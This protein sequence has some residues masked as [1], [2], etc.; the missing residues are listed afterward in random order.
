MWLRNSTTTPSPT[1]YAVLTFPQA[2]DILDVDGDSHADVAV[3]GGG[4]PDSIAVFTNN[5]SGGL[6]TPSLL[7]TPAGQFV[8]MALRDLNADG[9]PDILL[10]GILENSVDVMFGVGDGTF[11]PERG[12]GTG[13][14]PTRL[15]TGDFH[16]TGR[17]DVA[18]SCGRDSVISLLAN[19]GHILAVPD[20]ASRS[21]TTLAMRVW[22]VPS[23]GTAPQISC[24]LPR[25]ETITVRAVDVAGRQIGTL[26]RKIDR[27]GWLTIRGEELVGT[28]ARAGMYFCQ[29][30][31]NGSSGSSRFLIVW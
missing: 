1:S 2:M 13:A 6:V 25:A 5:G 9:H 3:M 22:P 15:V 30:E 21:G 29:V 27:A 20:Q 8:D 31:A 7:A 17:P 10:S 4:F 19:T 14:G 28:Q 23:L 12:Y 24:Y 16:G 11:A 18:V 26:R